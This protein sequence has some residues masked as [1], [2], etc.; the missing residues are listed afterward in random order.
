MVGLVQ[1]REVDMTIMPLIQTYSRYAVGEYSP[2]IIYVPFGILSASDVSTSNVF[3]Y[4]LTFDWKVWALLLSA[5][6]ILALLI[7]LSDFAVHRTSWKKMPLEVHQWGWELFGNLLYES[8]PRTPSQP[9]GRIA[10]MTWLL[11]VLV[12]A[13][14]FAGHLKSSMAVKN[15]P[16]QV[17]T[18]QD[19]VDRPNMRPIIWKGSYYEALISGS[20]SP[21]LRRL[22]RSVIRTNG[23]QL[24][25]IMYRDENMREVVERRAVFMVDHN[26]QRFHMAAFCRREVAPS[27]HF[28]REIIEEHRL[29]FLMSRFMRRD[30]HRRIHIRVTWLYES[31]LVDKWMADGLGDWQRC[32]RRAGGHAAEDLT[33]NDTLATFVLWAIVMS[34]AAGALVV[35]TLRRP[36]VDRAMPDVES[37]ESQQRRVPARRSRAAC[38]RALKLAVP[39][40]R[41]QRETCAQLEGR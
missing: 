1:R 32:V 9:S 28:G 21:L 15:E 26:S 20:P 6:P 30:L 5:I 34:A 18:V 33:V 23:S 16:P 24:G 13:N 29:S 11:A 37:V 3:G 19:V 10:L 8:S 25:R 31:G 39:T 27:F 35:E 41:R 4:I 38:R 14:S 12:I 17:D 22:W 36:R 7:S 40:R 2:A